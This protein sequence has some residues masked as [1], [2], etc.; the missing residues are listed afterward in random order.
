MD[1]HNNSHEPSQGDT[2][3]SGLKNVPKHQY[4]S[5]KAWHRP[6]A[7]GHHLKSKRNYK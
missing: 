5:N 7:P 1:I 6:I 3:P 2:D 4:K